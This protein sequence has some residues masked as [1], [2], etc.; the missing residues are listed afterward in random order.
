MKKFKINGIDHPAVA[1]SNVDELAT[2]YCDV[3]GYEQ[4]FRDPRPIWL[5]KATDGTL[6]EILP[7]DA[8]PRPV[9]TNLTPGWSHVAF[10]VD[11]IVA[12]IQHLDNYGITWSSVLSP[13]LAVDESAHSLT[14]KEMFY[15]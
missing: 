1:A 5:L 6:L 11:D 13:Q 8:T 14:R 12:A 10:Q 4:W 15:S 9:R 2:W 7:I 3:L